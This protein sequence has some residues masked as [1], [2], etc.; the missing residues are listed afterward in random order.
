[1]STRAVPLKPDVLTNIEV[2]AYPYRQ[3][4]LILTDLVS[5]V[6]IRDEAERCAMEVA[7]TIDNVDGLAN[8]KLAPGTWMTV[9]GISPVSGKRIHL[10]PRLYVWERTV[11]D[12]RRRVSTV[13]ALDT[14]SFLQR[15]SEQSYFFRKTKSKPKGWT[16]SEIAEAILN[17]L[18]LP[19]KVVPTTYRINWF[20]L[21]DVTPY[22][23]IL[24][25]YMRDKQITGATYRI[26]A[27]SATRGP[28]GGITNPNMV[29]IEP[30]TYQDYHWELDDENSILSAERS[31]SLEGVA[32]EYRGVVLDKNGKE[33]ARATAKSK[34]TGRYG[35]LRKFE[36]LPKGTKPGDAQKV[37]N[38]QLAKFLTLKRTARVDAI[39]TPTLRASDLV[40]I[41]DSGTGLSGN[42]FVSSINHSITAS[43]HQMEVELSYTAKFPT[44]EVAESEWNP[45]ANRN[46]STDGTTTSGGMGERVVAWAATQKG[47]PYKWGGTTPGVGLDCSALTQLAWKNGA[48]V[49]IPRVTYDQIKIG[50]QVESVAKAAPGD[51]IFYGTGHMALYAGDGKQWEARQT[52]TRVSLNPVRTAKVTTIRRPVPLSRQGVGTPGGSGG[53]QESAGSQTVNIPALA[54]EWSYASGQFGGGAADSTTP[55]STATG[56]RTNE[57][58]L[59]QALR[60]RGCPSYFVNLADTFISAGTQ[61][62]VNPIFLA[63]IACVESLNGKYGPA[64]NSRNITGFGG[65][66][67]SV[68]FPSFE[69]CIMA[70]AGP[71]C[72][73]SSDYSNRHTIADIGAKYA[74]PGA[75]ND[76]G[77]NKDWPSTVAR[78]FR[79][80]GGGNASI[81]M[82]GPQ[83]RQQVASG[84]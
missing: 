23:A 16:A 12:L 80:L 30:V 55:S 81:P 74:P 21:Q 84:G 61:Y 75:S 5:A 31:E 77:G 73:Q 22:E 45:A 59:Q 65:G 3:K 72:L 43:S 19:A 57:A 67:G 71:R 64:Q 51:L 53:G 13:T 1:M 15:Q 10:T 50:S 48:N 8:T 28:G 69:A 25:A 32:T 46:S 36:V 56:D 18:G 82:K 60:R 52:G 35:T 41:T 78:V 7:F 33:L 29:V 27:G 76:R 44:V 37:A 40:G 42:Y 26:R 39:G 34:N 14:V 68:T 9:T 79:E 63:A 83:Y 38:K 66:P 4:S 17:D 20:L 2:T 70:T 11:S 24:K 58:A 49:D 54:E 47:V 6:E 62:S